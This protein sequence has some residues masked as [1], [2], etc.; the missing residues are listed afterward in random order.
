MAD[1]ACIVCGFVRCQALKSHRLRRVSCLRTRFRASRGE[2][3]KGEKKRL[4]IFI[5]ETLIDWKIKRKEG[6]KDRLTEERNPK[7]EKTQ[8]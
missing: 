2:R 4:R 3:K 7:E 6:R 5:S 8:G 1:F